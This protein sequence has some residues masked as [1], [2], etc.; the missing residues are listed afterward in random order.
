MKV[1]VTIGAPTSR[2]MGNGANCCSSGEDK[3]LNMIP[4]FF[5]LRIEKNAFTASLDIFSGH[6]GS[7]HDNPG[8][9]RESANRDAVPDLLP[10]GT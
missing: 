7:N 8:C 10:P 2:D 3:I 5:C 4:Q 9:A 1:D 6:V